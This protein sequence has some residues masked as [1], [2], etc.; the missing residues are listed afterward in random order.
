MEKDAS[1]N[2]VQRLRESVA[3][4]LPVESAVLVNLIDALVVGPRPESA[5]ETT[6]SPVWGYDH[7]N[8][9]AG[10]E[11]AG[12]QLGV[13]LSTADWLR[14]L[15]QARLDW[16][17]QQPA[18][19]GARIG[20]R[21]VRVL[22]GSDYPRPKTK[23]VPLAYV[24][25]ANGMRLGH[26]LSLLA[27]R[28]AEGSWTL[29]LE[30]NWI[31]PRTHP[32]IYG[33]VQLEEH[34]RR[35]G[36]PGDC[37]LDVDAGYTNEPFLRPVS[38]LG[39]P[40]L[41]RAASNRCFYL[42]PPPYRGMGR[43][44]VR[45]RKFKLNDARTL[46]PVDEFEQRALADGSRLAV[47]RWNDV[48]IRKWPEKRLI[49]YRVI[50]YRADGKPRYK[51]PLWLIYVPAETRIDQ[52]V[53]G[54]PKVET[55]NL[56]VAR[57][58]ASKVETP[59]MESPKND[60]PSPL[61]AAELYEARFGVEHGIR[62]M[63]RELGLTAGQFNSLAAEGRIQVWVEMVACAFWFLWSLSGMA[64]TAD[65]K[66]IPRWW[67]RENIT[68]GAVRRMASGLLLGLG[69]NKPKPKTRGKSPGRAR[70][71]K[72]E[73]RKRFKPVRQAAQTAL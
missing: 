72:L 43:P 8:L 29:P 50:E 53:I 40:I 21:R 59:T 66:L 69:W 23:T 22:D 20:N 7:S 15:R 18:R 12:D 38:S 17:L 44:S 32:N 41:G 2:S 54:T 28:V 35:H 19:R 3:G 62:F 13:D 58:E 45:G 27:E 65:R 1:I 24:H 9:Y 52:A 5:V 71:T 14:D 33:V 70:G 31:P 37:L 51:R 10:I 64:K 42:P 4:A 46:P 56:E 63:K 6:L 49:L 25:G 47:S 36:W 60:L 61:E 55:S 30:I 11:R 34:V 26:G 73:A 68:P 39:I 57:L 48:R 67:K 16:L